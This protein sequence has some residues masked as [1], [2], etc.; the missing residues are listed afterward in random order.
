MTAPK[1]GHSVCV[2]FDG[3][4]FRFVDLA[5]LSAYNAV[6]EEVLNGADEGETTINLLTDEDAE[7]GV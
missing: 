5:F 4:F 7:M 6:V 3:M 2:A 1:L